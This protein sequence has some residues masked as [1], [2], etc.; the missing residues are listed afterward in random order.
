MLPRVSLYAKPEELFGWLEGQGVT[1]VVLR[2][3]HRIGHDQ[4]DVKD[5]DL[6][7]DDDAIPA[8]QST[9]KRR[10]SGSKVD[11]YGVRGLHGSDYHGFPHLPETLARQLLERKRMVG[12]IW[13]PHPVDELNALLYHVVYH[14][15][16][17][18][19]FH[20]NDPAQSIRSAYS[21][22]LD[23]LQ[24]EVGIRLSPTHESYHTHLSTLELTV[25]E[26]WL[27][28]YLEHDCWHLRKSFFHDWLQNQHPGE[29]NLFVIR[30]IAV[31]H[32]KRDAL[33]SRLEERFQIIRTKLIP[34][35]TRFATR[36]HLRGGKWRRGGYPHVAVVVFDL[37][38]APITPEQQAV[39]PF[40]FNRNQFIKL[41]WRDWF[42]QN[43]SAR[44]KDNPIHSTDNEAEALGHLPLFF[45]K[46]E[47]AEIRESLLALRL[48]VKD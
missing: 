44:S 47:R 46:Q 11:L 26:E 10:R 21:D 9:F 6:L 18:S 12:S 15:N 38:P 13:L 37:A 1:Y 25:S 5:I 48:E 20:H 3:G 32:G 14:K 24:K 36:K 40:V 7:I 45:S 33:L 4:V 39:H 34:W 35:R 29:L 8:M 16:V 19:G 22:R 28:A 23:E 17:Q 30:A 41:Q 42:C 27:T 43:T 2:D 31:K